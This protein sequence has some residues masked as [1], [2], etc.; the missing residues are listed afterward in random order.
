MK[1][2]N[3]TF[4]VALA[5]RWT[6]RKWAQQQNQA[7]QSTTSASSSASAPPSGWAVVCINREE[8]S[9]AWKHFSSGGWGK[10][11]FDRKRKTLD[12]SSNLRHFVCVVLQRNYWLVVYG[13]RRQEPPPLC[14]W[15]AGFSESESFGDKT[16]VAAGWDAPRMAL[17]IVHN[18]AS[19]F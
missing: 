17:T 8:R 10:C 11:T 4:G 3:S 19:N 2:F 18:S 7:R 9:L 14:L 5:P 16:K 15:L 13:Y 6:R 1:V 12:M